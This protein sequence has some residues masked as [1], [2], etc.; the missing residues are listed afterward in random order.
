MLRQGDDM[1]QALPPPNHGPE[2]KRNWF[3]GVLRRAVLRCLE[4]VSST[5][6]R[7]AAFIDKGGRQQSWSTAE[8]SSSISDSENLKASRLADEYDAALLLT[9]WREWMELLA[10]GGPPFGCKWERVDSR[11]ETGDELE[12]DELAKALQSKTTFFAYELRKFGI[13]E[14]R[15]GQ[16]VVVNSFT[17]TGVGGE[18]YY[19]PVAPRLL[20]DVKEIWRELWYMHTLDSI[21][22]IC[23]GSDDELHCD[24]MT[25]V[26]EK[27]MRLPA[28]SRRSADAQ[29]DR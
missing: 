5:F 26:H 23:P 12:N 2:K 8:S 16:F 3:L 25:Q 21:A 10:N 17:T 4:L 22:G 27:M 18:V 20:Y 14:L 15:S 19:K 7:A 28:R 6:K 24:L 9:R 29:E 11:P 13:D 1:Q